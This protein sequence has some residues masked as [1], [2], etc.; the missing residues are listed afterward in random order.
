MLGMQGQT[1]QGCRDSAG[2]AGT[3]GA[4]MQGQTVQGCMDSVGMQGQCRDAGTVW[5]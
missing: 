5:R 4:G 1:E 3:D 2:I